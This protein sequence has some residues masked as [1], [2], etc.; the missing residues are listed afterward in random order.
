MTALSS[1][2]LASSSSPSGSGP[3]IS[4]C[5]AAGRVFGQ[6]DDLVDRAVDVEVAADLGG[7]GAVDVV[8]A[9]VL[10]VVDEV[11]RF[12]PGCRFLAGFGFGAFALAFLLGLFEAG[13]DEAE[14]GRVDFVLVAFV[15][16]VGAVGEQRDAAFEVDL[17]AFGFAVGLDLHVGFG[18]FAFGAGL[19][20]AG[21]R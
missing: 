12:Q 16:D 6:F 5:D 4:S 13:L 1:S 18:Q 21:E 20:R 14:G 17:F 2:P 9:L 7:R 8:A 10:E 15:A 11:G 3:A 19:E